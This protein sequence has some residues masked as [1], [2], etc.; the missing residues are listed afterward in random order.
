MPRSYVELANSISNRLPPAGDYGL[1]TKRLLTA[2]SFD[3]AD[4]AAER[5]LPTEPV[6]LDRSPWSSSTARELRERLLE[7]M[8]HG[9]ARPLDLWCSTDLT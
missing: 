4:G 8:A 5:W 2:M 3:L 7:R 9:A 6:V 1:D